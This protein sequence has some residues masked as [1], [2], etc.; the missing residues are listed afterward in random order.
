MPAAGSP[1]KPWERNPQGTPSAV[2]TGE[3]GGAGAAAA[4]TGATAAASGAA[5]TAAA[6]GVTSGLGTSGMGGYG[7]GMYGNRYGSG[8]YGGGMY[9]GGSMYG[10]SMYGG[11]GGMYGGGYG[12]GM[13]MMGMPGM[14]PQDQKGQ[15]IIF[16]MQRMSEMVG[17]TS[18][19]LHQSMQTIMASIGN[20]SG[21]YQQWQQAG[22]AA[23]APQQQM[24]QVQ[25]A[26]GEQQPPAGVL[27]LV[28]DA[29]ARSPAAAPLQPD[30][31]RC[32][33]RKKGGIMSVLVKLLLI[34]VCWQISKGICRKIESLF[35]AASAHN[36]HIAAWDQFAKN[37]ALV[38]QAPPAAQGW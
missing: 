13:G 7:G 12:M 33:K 11:M 10:G 23:E 35:A 34:V 28:A 14:G 30:A 15:Q 17:M 21:L 16:M 9:G 19:M 38:A 5:D 27:P 37:P 20:F 36:A 25:A 22:A 32:S 2:V 29:D 1:P 3:A 4:T 26:Q 31:R 24:L 18:Q 8:M 6:S